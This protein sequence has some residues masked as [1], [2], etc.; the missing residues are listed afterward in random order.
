MRICRVA[1]PRLGKED[2]TE[3]TLGYQRDAEANNSAIL[4][5]YL[6]QIS[7]LNGIISHMYNEN[8]LSSYMIVLHLATKSDMCKAQGNLS[9]FT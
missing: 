9:Q 4:L 3:S 7:A 5:M 8:L 2:S 1:A 6:F